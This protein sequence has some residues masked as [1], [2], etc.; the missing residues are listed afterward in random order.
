VTTI[1]LGF[2]AGAAGVVA[3]GFAAVV[4]CGAAGFGGVGAGAGG[5][6]GFGSVGALGASALGLA[7]AADDAD[8]DGECD[9]LD[10][11]RSGGWVASC[12]LN[13]P[14]VPATVVVLDG[15]DPLPPHP[16][17][18]AATATAPR[19]RAGRLRRKM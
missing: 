16:A 3:G 9:F 18:K 13:V 2:G 1:V 8:S 12:A 11:E 19:T 6:A 10:E 7:A 17:T 14:L 4:C 15:A 5:G